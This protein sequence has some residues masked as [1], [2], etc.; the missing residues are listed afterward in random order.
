MPIPKLRDGSA[1]SV[2]RSR[3]EA[4]D[5]RDSGA[6]DMEL[7]RLPA[8]L[9]AKTIVFVHPLLS[10]KMSQLIGSGVERRG[11]THSVVMPRRDL[12]VPP[13]LVS[14]I[15]AR[16]L[17]IAVDDAAFAHES[18]LDEGG[19]L[20]EEVLAFGPDLVLEVLAIEGSGEDDGRAHAKVV[21]HVLLDAIVGRGGEG[22]EGDVGE[23]LL[24]ATHL[25]VVGACARGM[26]S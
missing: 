10:D 6:D 9:D 21:H 19:N 1:V 15:L 3:K 24:E 2:A 23:V 8:F 17:R 12:V 4:N 11:S 13:Q 22:D 16:L 25:L 14:D 7:G 26:E 18:R 5:S 20:G